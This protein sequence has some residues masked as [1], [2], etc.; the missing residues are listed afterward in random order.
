MSDTNKHFSHE[1]A[2]KKVGELIKDIKMAML[3]TVCEEDGSLHSRP[4]VTQQV[5]FDGD[6][7]FF[8]E[9]NTAKVKEIDLEHEVNV[10][11]ADS[12]HNRYV[13]VS[14]AGTF[15]EDRAKMKE[16]WNPLYKAWFPKALEDPNI[17]LLKVSV[18]RA[19]YWDSPSSTMMQV[20]GF[21][22][23]VMTGKR[24]EGSEHE[25]VTM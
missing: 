2:V 21:V 19:E 11:F 5:E 7:W 9:N 22:K 4:M 6:L 12:D 20:A 23:A 15:S 1:E 10:S 25:R 17:L 18:R 8:T 13:S 24:N 16:L 3:T 14:G